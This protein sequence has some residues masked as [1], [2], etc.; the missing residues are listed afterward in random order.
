MKIKVITLWQP[1]ASLVAHGYKQLETRGWSTKYRGSLLIHSAKKWSKEQRQFHEQHSK[2]ILG[3]ADLPFGSMLAI[4]EL[5]E[6]VP[7]EDIQEI[8][9]ERERLFGDYSPGRYAWTLD[10][11]ELFQTPVPWKGQQGL[12][13]VDIEM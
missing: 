7:V 11:M 3:S 1:W 2:E 4:C 12:W 8:L 5:T 6:V 10:N 13:Q 9:T